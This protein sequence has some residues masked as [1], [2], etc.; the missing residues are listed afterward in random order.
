M[1]HA[2][3]AQRCLLSLV[4]IVL[5]IVVI[6]FNLSVHRGLVETTR[7]AIAVIQVVAMVT[8]M[9]TAVGAEVAVILG[10]VTAGKGLH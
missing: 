5:S 4:K 6:V 2:G 9:V 3:G 7:V 1:P 10:A 8:A